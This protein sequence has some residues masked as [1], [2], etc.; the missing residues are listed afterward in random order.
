[1]TM[2]QP[3]HVP[4]GAAGRAVWA[5]S[6]RHK[7]TRYTHPRTP[8]SQC[9][10][11]TIT[12]QAPRPAAT[13]ISVLSSQQRGAETE[14]RVPLVHPPPPR[15]SLKI[16]LRNPSVLQQGYFEQS[17]TYQPAAHLAYLATCPPHG[18]DG[19][20]ARRPPQPHCAS[21]TCT[22]PRPY[23]GPT[24]QQVERASARPALAAWSL[25]P[26]S[27][28]GPCPHSTAQQGVVGAAMQASARAACARAGA[29]APARQ[30]G[31][32]PL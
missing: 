21:K 22:E 15:G 12:I 26:C 32:P 29:A 18:L 1:M 27:V 3:R 14:R 7:C 8:A 10:C 11:S 28:P 19:K 25:A 16:S 6:T 17:H 23:Q 13:A 4:G 5:K 20:V 2:S 31:S 9:S 30:A 24:L